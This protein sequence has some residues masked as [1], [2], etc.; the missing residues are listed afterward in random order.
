M[1]LLSQVIF[2]ISNQE[3]N[4]GQQERQDLWYGVH[5]NVRDVY[6]SMYDSALMRVCERVH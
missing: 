1:Q 4:Q 2:A 6:E 3:Q 5:E